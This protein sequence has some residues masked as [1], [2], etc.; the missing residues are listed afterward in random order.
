M[1]ILDIFKRTPKPSRKRGFEAA[2]TGRLFSDWMTQTKTADSDLRYALRAM[3]AR[4]RD[5]CQ[6]N[7]YAR[8]YLNL[9]STNVVGPKGITLQVRARELTGALDQIANQQLEAAFYAW[10]QPGVCTVDGRLS[11][12][13]AQ[14]VF[15]ESVARDGECFVLFVED[16]ANPFRFRL[17][18]IDPDLI[19]QDKNEIL[20]NGGQIRMGIEV[21]AAGRP[22][23]YHVRVRP[24]DDY[25]IG[26]TNPRTERI[27]ADRMI[28]AFRPDR[29]GQNR[30]SPWTATAMTRLKM[31]GGYEE[32]ELVAARISASK[33]GF[34]VSESGD[35]YQGDG[36]NPDGSLSMDV[37]P[38]QFAQL[39]AGVD[40]KSYDPQHPSTAFR[41]FEK[42]MLRGI[43]SGLGVSYTSL[44]NDLEA[45]SYSSIRQ[46]LLEER[47]HW[48]MVQNWVI[49]HFCQPV[50]LRWLRQTLD[51]GIINL[52]ASKF[53]KFS[54]TIWVPRGWQWVDPRNEAEA[55]ILAINN[56]LMTKTQALAERGLDLEDVLLEQQAETEL[57][58][59]IA[60]DS[61]GAVASDAE[62]AF[63][64]VQ[65]T[66]MI[67]ILQKV[68]EGILPKESAVQ[69]L[70]QSFPIS[71]EDA[72]KMV[73]PIEPAEFFLEAAPAS[74]VTNG[75]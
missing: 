31:L 49:E 74:G 75:G 70:I 27:S 2:N 42:A 6:N 71:A 26:S 20:A 22:V 35:E 24:P 8:R 11:W 13:D 19:D 28:H 52:P 53:L 32:A 62:Q 39:P 7:D 5:L 9:V 25:Q 21:D 1:S 48:R 4:S 16:N 64:G 66:A 65:I 41:D 33:M 60:P 57:S 37:Q 23:A 63:T 29:I 17:Q 34:F 3:R 36:N 18:F 51:A 69:I 14:R 56:G 40:F 10:G 44:A 54:A 15:I 61:A 68:R 67:D 38:G 46:G 30:G 50:Y 73:D 12:I 45:V 59:K 43:A 58:D 47:D 55:Q 72:R